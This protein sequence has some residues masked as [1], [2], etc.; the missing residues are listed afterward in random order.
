VTINFIREN[1]IQ[2]PL[3]RRSNNSIQKRGEDYVDFAPDRIVCQDATA[4]MALQFHASREKIKWQ[5]HN[6]HRDHFDSSKRRIQRFGI[7]QIK[8]RSIRFFLS[9]TSK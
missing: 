6:D 2:S 5:S 4:Q 9:S 8:F 7:K 1:F 3:G